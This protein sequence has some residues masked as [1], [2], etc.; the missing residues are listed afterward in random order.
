MT[1]MMMAVI[2][3]IMMLFD[4]DYAHVGGSGALSWELMLSL[5]SGNKQTNNAH[6]RRAEK[7]DYDN[8]LNLK[9][10]NYTPQCNRMYGKIVRC[11]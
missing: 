3:I 7:A 10:V 8:M 11:H 1:I 5:C 4:E 6:G 2:M 9:T